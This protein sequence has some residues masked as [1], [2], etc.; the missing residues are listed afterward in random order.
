M[1]NRLQKLY[2]PL[3]VICLFL[4]IANDLW[5]KGAFHNQL[6]GKLSD[7]CGLFVFAQFWSVM[8]PK[9]KLTLHFLVALFF[10]WWKSPWSQEFIDWVSI[11]FFAIG[12]TIDFSD[13]WALIML[14]LSHRFKPQHSWKVSPIP[15]VLISCFSFVAT[16]LPTVRQYMNPPQY[17]LLHNNYLIY[18]STDADF[19]QFHLF[20]QEDFTIVK[21]NYIDHM[22]SPIWDDDFAKNSL[23]KQLDKY[24]VEQFKY[25]IKSN[26]DIRTIQQQLIVKGSHKFEVKLDS[27]VDNLS[28]LDSY[29]HGPFERYDTLGHLKTKGYYNHGLEDSLWTYYDDTGRVNLQKCFADG[30]LVSVKQLKNDVLVSSQ[31]YLTRSE[32]LAR[33]KFITAILALI[34][35]GLFYYTNQ[36]RRNS[37]VRFIFRGIEGCAVLFLLPLIP[38]FVA[39][40]IYKI[41][42]DAGYITYFPFELLGI[43]IAYIIMGMSY[44][45]LN[46]RKMLINYWVILGYSLSLS[47]LLVF[48]RELYFLTELQ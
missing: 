35:V 26:D 14:P 25:R 38:L 4:L 23:K 42:P 46:E 28:F 18:H 13:L 10:I 43:G 21:V 32:K 5:L 37:P 9:R 17:L 20:S 3:F 45:V 36:L 8:V 15:I 6:T 19:D 24:L 33:K 39:Y 48:I 29:L 1:K 11:Q 22:N 2:N 41:L 12:R 30:E 27:L 44:I 40:L 7:F 34:V 31:S 16:T 47:V